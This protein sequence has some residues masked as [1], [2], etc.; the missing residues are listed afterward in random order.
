MTEESYH[1]KVRKA[2]FDRNLSEIKAMNLLQDQ[3]IISDLCVWITDIAEADCDRAEMFLLTY[4]P[5]T[6]GK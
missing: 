1:A 2:A 5:E 6:T 3:G 4:E